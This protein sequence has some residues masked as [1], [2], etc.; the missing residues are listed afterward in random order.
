MAGPF[1]SLGT[2][3][4]AMSTFKTW[5]DALA[6]NVANAYTVRSTSESAF[7]ERFIIARSRGTGASADGGVEVSGVAYGDANG[8]LV[9]EPNHPLADAN[10]MVRYPDMDLTDQMTQ[11]MVAQRAYQMNV[12]AFE[13]AR[14]AFQTALTIGR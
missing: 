7:Q 6:D 11:L 4:S 1:E 13:R 5:I 3:A 9:Y 14:D 10:G 8:R 12:G 2:P